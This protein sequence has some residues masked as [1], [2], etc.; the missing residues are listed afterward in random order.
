MIYHIRRLFGSI[1]LVGGSG[2]SPADER[3][4]EVPGQHEEEGE[5]DETGGVGG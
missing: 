2:P 4:G 5:E 3:T 1:F